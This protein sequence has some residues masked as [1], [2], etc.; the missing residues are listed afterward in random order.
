M[1]TPRTLIAALLATS[2]LTAGCAG[3]TAGHSDSAAKVI[4]RTP[5]TQVQPRAKAASITGPT[6]AVLADR[7]ITPVADDPKQALPVTVRSK[8]GDDKD[9][10]VT[11]TSRVVAFDIAGSITATVWGLGF[12]DSLVGRDVA[13]SFPG[14]EKLPVVTRDGHSINVEAVLKLEPTL[15]ITDG[16]IGPRDVVDQLRDAG[17]T[18][19]YVDNDATYAGAA[20]LARDV[21]AIYGAPAVGKQLAKRITDDVDSTRAAVNKLREDQSPLR[22]VFVYLRG[23]AGVYDIL[24]KEW[25]AS[26]LITALGGLDVAAEQGW[27]D[28]IPMTDESLVAADPDLVLVMTD[29]IKSVGGLDKLLADRPALALTTAGR[30][31]RFVDM[32]DSDILSFGPRSAGVLDALT[33]AVYAPESL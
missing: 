5:L 7:R 18:L 19:V 2:V 31:R 28:S 4:E 25:G 10:R 6:T 23:S 11:D 1:T 8:Q 17:V 12:G 16:S 20:K 9:I 15:V 27:A 13:A 33:R 21:A 32:A 22:M 26:D 3:P 29:G 24:G 14:T 30:N